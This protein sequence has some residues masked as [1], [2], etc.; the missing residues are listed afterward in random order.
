[1]SI[2]FKSRVEVP[3]DV[4]VS[5][6]DG[7]SIILNLTTESYF[8][9]DEVGASMWNVVTHAGSIEAAYET[10]KGKWD[11]DP[12][13]PALRPGL[14]VRA[15]CHGR[16]GQYQL[17]TT[18]RRF[19]ALTPAERA[20]LVRALM[21]LPIIRA[22]VVMLGL[23]RTQTWLDWAE[24]AWSRRTN[25][26][27]GRAGVRTVERMVNAAAREGIV[28]ATCL[29]RSLA[30]CALLRSSGVTATLKVGVRKHLGRLQAHAWVETPGARSSDSAQEDGFVVMKAPGSAAIS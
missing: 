13:V 7:E 19:L 5:E 17:V 3:A 6:L 12:T 11:V 20:L 4:L 16:T 9:L 23:R 2:N 21:L 28:R 25:R 10:L 24:R 22:S 15:A 1:M 14:S 26:L 18:V 30:T 29:P 8:G 27:D